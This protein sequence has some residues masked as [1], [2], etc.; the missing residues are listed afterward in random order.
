M[1]SVF[2]VHEVKTYPQK[3]T[4]LQQIRVGYLLPVEQVPEGDRVQ[5]GAPSQSCAADLQQYA[6]LQTGPGFYEGEI[7]WQPMG[8]QMLP[9]LRVTRFLGPL[10]AGPVVSS[11]A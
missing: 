8:K 11:K 1:S 4:G 7:A 5:L 3:E 6:Q 10:P 2:I 9:K